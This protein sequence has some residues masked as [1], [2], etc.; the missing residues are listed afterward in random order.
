MIFFEKLQYIKLYII[1]FIKIN[2]TV[3]ITIIA[4]LIALFSFI[5]TA[6]NTKLIED[7][8]RKIYFDNLLEKIN[9]L[10]SIENNLDNE[11]LK[12]KELYHQSLKKFKQNQ[13]YNYKNDIIQL[14]EHHRKII[15]YMREIRILYEYLISFSNQ[16]TTLNDKNL[17]LLKIQYLLFR[18]NSKNL[19][20]TLQK[21]TSDLKRI[22]FK[23]DKM[24]YAHDFN[25]KSMSIPKQ[26]ALYNLFMQN[27]D[28]EELYEIQNKQNEILIKENLTDNLLDVNLS[29]NILYYISK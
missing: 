25:V 24:K 3:I 10:D 17:E 21:K 5:A 12:Y 18:N 7:Q 23:M 26:Y 6:Q 13:Q 2:I 29:N 8:T 19:I 9:K 16:W 27:I 14:T 22:L 28:T 20:K 11:L 4:T 15:K 1:K